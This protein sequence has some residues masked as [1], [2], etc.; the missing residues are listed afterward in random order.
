MNDESTVQFINNTALLRGG[1]VYIDLSNCYDGGIVFTNFTRYDVISFI[2]NSAGLTGNSLYFN[3][4]DSCEV[5]RDHSR[6]DSAF[7]IPYKFNFTQSRNINGSAVGTSPYEINICS[8]TKCNSMKS[9]NST[10]MCVISNNKML[11]QLVYFDAMICNY[12]DIAGEATYFEAN[13]INCGITFRLLDNTMLVQNGIRNKISFSSLNADR[14]LENDTSITV[15]LSSLDQFSS[16]YRQLTATLTLTLSSCYNGFLFTTQSQQCECYNKD[17]YLQCEEDVARIKLGYWFGVFA[18]KYIL[19]LCDNNYCN[20]F[21]NREETKNGFYNLPEKID[22]QCNPHRTGVACGECSEGYTLAYNSPDCIS[23]DK[24]SPGMT[25]L[26]VVLT[27]LYWIA[28]VAILFGVAYYCKMQ[29]KIS[30]G[31]FYGIMYFYSSVDILLASKLYI[32]DKVFYTVATL[33]SFAKPSPQLL[34]KLCFIN[35]LDAIDQQFIHYCH[36][37]FILIILIGVIIVAKF[38]KRIG[39]YV[40]HCITQVVCLFLLF[41]YSSLMTISLLLLRPLKFHDIDGL[42]TY[43]SP[44]LEYFVNRHAVYASI[45]IF[46]GFVL[47]IIFSF[48]LMEPC[49]NTLLSKCTPR[50]RIRSRCWRR[51]KLYIIIKL[52]GFYV[53]TKQIV[54]QLQ[55][56]YKYRYRCFS[57]YY[58]ICRLVI[59][60]IAYF[61][62]DDYN[63]GTYYL[64]TACVIIATIHIWIQPYKSTTLNAIDTTILLNMLLIVNLNSFNFSTST[65]VGIIITLVIAPLLLFIALGAKKTLGHPWRTCLSQL[66]K[67][68]VRL[69]EQ[70]HHRNR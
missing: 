58:L 45:A 67:L 14:D 27:A 46:C 23:V 43:L 34:G 28:I 13:C 24:C 15:K 39:F 8:T 44:H 56:C 5:I 57:A 42:H 65:S 6:N 60:S 30:L 70:I 12:F 25:V 69:V 52:G 2:N 61:A 33:S 66:K 17:D 7:Y 20:F 4:P 62:N 59:M 22:Y 50:C 63:N 49:M 11:G 55:D 9:M 51:M 1:A 41:A 16:N 26:V 18:G 53:R 40:D 32:A 47:T 31:Y 64:Q 37:V 38:C 35:N 10:S 54:D 48:L 19:S 3:I 36:V 29:A 68:S 21:T